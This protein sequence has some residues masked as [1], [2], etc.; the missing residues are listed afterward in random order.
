MKPMFI[1]Q[2]RSF[3]GDPDIWTKAIELRDL[4]CPDDTIM[5]E[6][7]FSW[8]KE[9]GLLIAEFGQKIRNEKEP[10]AKAEGGSG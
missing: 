3:N 10:Q 1:T 9:V 4:I 2:D 5:A 8:K 6:V 7:K